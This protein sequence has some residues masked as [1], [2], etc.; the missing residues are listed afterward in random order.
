MIRACIGLLLLFLVPL[1]GGL[2]WGN[3]QVEVDETEVDPAIAYINAQSPE[4]TPFREA[5]FEHGG[6]RLHYVEAGQGETV[7]FLHGFPS[8]WLSLFNQMV[9]LKEGYR[10]VAIDGLGAGRSDAPLDV[11]H[12]TLEN[13]STGVIALLD[14]LGADKVH[15]VGHD[16][17]STFAFGLAQRHP[18]RVL[19][20][21]GISAPPQNVLLASLQSDPNAR[22]AA[23]YIERLKSANP[24]LIVATGGHKRVWTGAYEPL[25]RAGHLTPEA[26][27]LMRD[28]TGDPRRLNA[29]INWYRANIPAPD[30]LTQTDFWPAPDA[31]LPMPALMI[32][33]QGSDRLAP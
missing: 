3:T 1:G 24:L 33:G 10:V 18:E 21:T 31:R 28:A 22:S 25:V 20:V 19:S 23:A 6:N 4:G 14:E 32:W 16:W 29:H 27:Q 17:G 8:Y 13:M 12:Y 5:Y 7:L 9:A 11:E 26:G 15:L 30:A 2:I